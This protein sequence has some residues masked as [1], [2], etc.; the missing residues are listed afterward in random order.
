MSLFIEQF[1]VRLPSHSRGLHLISDNISVALKEQRP[2]SVGTLHCLIQHT[3]AAISINENADPDV[4]V[5][6]ENWLD[7]NV[8]EDPVHYRHVDEGSDDM[9]AHIKTYLGGVDLTIPV[10]DSQMSL[11]IWQGIYL[12]EFRD[13][14]SARTIICTLTASTP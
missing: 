14:A 7:R 2:A 6:L 11:G 13:Q 3:S 8:P 12:C 5:D 4:R 10:N 9:P 1:I